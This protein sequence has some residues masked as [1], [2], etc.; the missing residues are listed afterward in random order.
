MH[1][2]T[3]SELDGTCH[4]WDGSTVFRLE[5]G[6]TWRQSAVRCRKVRLCCPAV[7]VWRLGER[8]WLELEGVP[9]IVPVERVPELR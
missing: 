1:L 2:V 7:R 4:G 3:E 8:H 9:E 6:Q 5:N